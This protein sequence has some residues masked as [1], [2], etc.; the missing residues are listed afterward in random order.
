MRAFLG[1]LE[2]LCVRNNGMYAAC[3]KDGHHTDTVF[4]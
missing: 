3:G 2:S 4:E 1:L